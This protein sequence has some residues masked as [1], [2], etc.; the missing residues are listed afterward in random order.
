M[1]VGA[2]LDASGLDETGEEDG[3][4]RECDAAEGIL[5]MLFHRWIGLGGESILPV[6]AAMDSA[7]F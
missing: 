4:V 5:V 2:E 7:R 6:I 1:A 3:E